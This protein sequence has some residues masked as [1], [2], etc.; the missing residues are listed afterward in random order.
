M[1][2]LSGGTMSMN[3]DV[4]KLEP[5]LKYTYKDKRYKINTLRYIKNG[6]TL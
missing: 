5:Y 2:N 6:I 3:K 4:L 1:K